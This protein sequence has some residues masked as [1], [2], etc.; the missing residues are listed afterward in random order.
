VLLGT[1]TVLALS[2]L[3]NSPEVSVLRLDYEYSTTQRH[4]VFLSLRRGDR[5]MRGVVKSR[6]S[7]QWGL[8]ISGSTPERAVQTITGGAAQSANDT[9]GNRWVLMTPR[10]FTT[11]TTLG[12]IELSSSSSTFPFGVGCAISGSTASGLSTTQSLIYQYHA[13]INERVFITGR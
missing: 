5:F 9:A 3:R 6:V 7:D 11:N 13:A 1:E 12:K 4:S 8:E 10:S 2:V